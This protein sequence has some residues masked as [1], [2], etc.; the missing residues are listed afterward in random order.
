LSRWKVDDTATALLM[1]RFYENLSKRKQPRAEALADAKKWLRE[2]PRSE[3][4]K[5]AATLADGA[6]RGKLTLL[7]PAEKAPTKLPSGDR[8]YEHPFYWAAF[9]LIGDPD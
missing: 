1:T 8:P 6:L 2:L 5:Q 4:E 7:R 9:T 3:I